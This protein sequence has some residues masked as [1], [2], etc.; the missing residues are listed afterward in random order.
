[1][2][3]P[4][5]HLPYPLIHPILVQFFSKWISKQEWKAIGTWFGLDAFAAVVAVVSVVV[6]IVVV[7]VVSPLG[8]KGIAVQMEV[9]GE[10]VN[11]DSD[12]DRSESFPVL[13]DVVVLYLQMVVPAMVVARVAV[14]NFAVL[15]TV[16]AQEGS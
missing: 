8:R 2:H 15:V 10:E 14:A 6:G 16:L 1:M 3:D 5:P 9:V 12:L 11:V 13:T 7:V 4:I